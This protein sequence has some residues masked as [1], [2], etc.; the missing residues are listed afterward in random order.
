MNE[1][2]LGGESA[3]WDCVE[4]RI[5]Q[6]RRGGPGSEATDAEPSDGHNRRDVMTCVSDMKTPMEHAYCTDFQEDYN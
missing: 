6:D 3:A 1:F 4:V 2:G 5:C